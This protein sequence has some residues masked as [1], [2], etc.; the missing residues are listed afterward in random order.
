[1]QLYKVINTAKFRLNEMYSRS[2]LN[3]QNVVI[4]RG[5]LINS[6]TVSSLCS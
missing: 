1:M 6:L 2:S 5:C 3:T 4:C